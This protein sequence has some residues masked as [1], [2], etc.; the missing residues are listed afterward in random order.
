MQYI[1][2]SIFM[3][4]I[5][6]LL[7]ACVTPE[8]KS[9]PDSVP[10]K[11]TVNGLIKVDNT[12]GR[13]DFS[14]SAFKGEQL[15][16][17][18]TISDV[19]ATVE[20]VSS[21][22]TAASLQTTAATYNATA[23]VC[24]NGNITSAGDMS[25]L[26]LM[27]ASGSMR[28]NDR[29]KLRNKAAK[30]FVSRMTGNDRAVVAWFSSSEGYTL[31]QE[32]TADKTLLEAGI[33]RAT[34]YR[35]TTNLWGSSY[36]GVNY[37]HSKVQGDK[38]KFVLVL[39]DGED[40]KGFK[41]PADIITLAQNTKVRMFMIGLEASVGSVDTDNMMKIAGDT[42]GF[43]R[44]VRDAQG[45]SELFNSAF[46]AAKSA[47]CVSVTFSPVPPKGTTLKGKLSFK[48]NDTSFEVDYEVVF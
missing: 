12:K 3:G 37:I 2:V 44:S 24:Q 10:D 18:G 48:V 23:A 34:L 21:R 5:L 35:G 6:L 19:S 20:S 31:E 36:D 41:K 47:G 38:N 27:D 14:V 8:K 13:A 26:I 46:N 17:E 42:N 9:V 33:D 39:T 25:A 22:A 11:A 4:L 40:T 29:D 32:L 30:E 43:Y 16:E 28:W 7:A 45:L 15:L 1:R